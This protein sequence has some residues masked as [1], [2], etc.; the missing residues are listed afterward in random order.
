[1]LDGWI[2]MSARFWDAKRINHLLFRAW[3]EEDIYDPKHFAEMLT[4]WFQAKKALSA[5]S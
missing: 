5:G 1:M 4:G 3:Y 2:S